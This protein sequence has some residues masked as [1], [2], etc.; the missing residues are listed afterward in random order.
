MRLLSIV[1]ALLAAS[2]VLAATLAAPLP[3]TAQVVGKAGTRTVCYWVFAESAEK[4]P[5]NGAWYLQGIPGKVTSLSQPCVVT[6][7]PDVLD[8][9]HKIV[10]TLKP[11]EGAVK[12]HIFKTEALPA[13]ALKVEAKT[14]GKE[15]IYYWVQGHNGWRHSALAGPFPASCDLKT[16]ANTLTVINAAPNQ[17]DHSIWV[18]KTPEP[19]MGRKP[20]V[21]G[22]RRSYSP[23]T[24]TAE[25]VTKN[26]QF[27]AW[28]PGPEAATDLREKPYGTGKLWLGS[29]AEL[30]FEDNGQPLKE[31]QAPTVNETAPGAFEDPFQQQSSRIVHNN[32]YKRVD[33]NGHSSM[34][35]NFYGGFFPME[36]DVFI[37][38]GGVNYYQNQPGAYPGYKST[39]GLANM[40]MT[41]YTESQF[42]GQNTMV[43]NFGM[44][45]TIAM[46]ANLELYAGNRDSGDEGAEIM[47][48]SVHRVASES[49]GTLAAD[50][51]AGA[52]RLAVSGL[53]GAAGRTLV[54]LS[55][56]QSDGRIDHVDNC[57]IYGDGTKWTPEMVG[58]FISFDVDNADK[59]RYWHQVIDVV[60]PTHLK[61]RMWTNWRFDCNLGYSRFIYNPAKG[62]KLPSY[63][64]KGLTVGAIEKNSHQLDALYTNRL[65]I[66]VLPKAREQA[67]ADGKY[68]IAPGT[69]FGDPWNEGGAH[70]DSLTQPWQKGDNLLVAAGH[71]QPITFWWGFLSGTLAPQDRVEG[72]AMMN[73][74]NRTANGNAFSCNAYQMGLHVDLPNG[75][76][77]N[78]VLVSGAPADAA[79]LAAPDVPMLRCYNTQIPYLQGS[80][81]ETALAIVAPTGERPLSVSKDTVTINGALRGNEKTRGRVEYQGDG[82]TA[83]YTVRFPSAYTVEPVVTVS[84]NQFARVRLVG[85]NT[86]GFTVEFESAP[87][88]GEKV[89]LW[90]M[91]QE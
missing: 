24:H 11:V 62:Q 63:A 83:R 27:A 5:T 70:V 55:Q 45:D 2:V 81:K 13:P 52:T 88:A 41:S 71:S 28:G 22:M 84:A 3:P 15:T 17:T 39:F 8:A 20:Q 19:P 34:G 57:D 44:G 51:P 91:A 23:V 35:P 40:S 29:T 73:Y 60:S 10:L 58:W 48:A 75:R 1:T 53:A 49:R 43:R 77:G 7:A 86:R 68:Q 4:A 78:G 18:T 14:A 54:N 80:E 6:N 72:I 16:F 87:K 79:F 76:E 66:G 25:W 21:I 12:Y 85:V 50:A 37:N 32:T 90:W 30:I 65:S 89:V 61:I 9:E 56:V 67:A 31:Q 38:R 36:L 42:V 74:T 59:V 26:R 69:T 47:R 33:F 64:D 82:K 46:G